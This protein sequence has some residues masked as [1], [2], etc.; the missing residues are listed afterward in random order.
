[1]LYQGQGIDR[2]PRAHRS[3][4]SAPYYNRNNNYPNT[5]NHPGNDVPGKNGGD[6]FGSVRKCNSCR[7]K[8][9]LMKDCRFK[10]N[11]T[12]TV[13]ILVRQEPRNIGRILFEVCQH[14]EDVMQAEEEDIKEL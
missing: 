5:H 3:K 2:V 1:M 7:S 12:K 4:S 10:M 6:R 11:L 8:D 9:Y 13:S 14:T